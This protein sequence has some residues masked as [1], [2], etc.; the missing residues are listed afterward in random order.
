[1]LFA[2]ASELVGALLFV[3]GLS[4]RLA[5]IPLMVIRRPRNPGTPHRFDGPLSIGRWTL[6]NETDSP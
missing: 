3:A 4:T 2:D 6:R 1:V 5:S